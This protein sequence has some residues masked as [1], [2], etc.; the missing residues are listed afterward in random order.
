MT[1]DQARIVDCTHLLCQEAYRRGY[2]AHLLIPE[3]ILIIRDWS[4]IEWTRF[5]NVRSEDDARREIDGASSEV[6]A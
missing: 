5:V 4:G 6:W 3:N 1:F 2:S